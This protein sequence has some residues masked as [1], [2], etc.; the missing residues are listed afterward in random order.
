MAINPG[1]ACAR[2]DSFAKWRKIHVQMEEAMKYAHKKPAASAVAEPK[3]ASPYL[4]MGQMVGRKLETEADVLLAVRKG[5]SA[6]AAVGFA[7][8]RAVDPKLIAPESTLRRRVEN[9]QLL[10][11]D[12]SERMMRLARISSRAEGLF[13]DQ[14]KARVWLL[15]PKALVSGEP[16]ISPLEL[17]ITESGARIVEST[18]LR[19]EHGMP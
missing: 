16:P 9:N 6:R 19:A 15:T 2:L 14:A 12:E 7:E 8:G 1:V 5:L 10:T 4:R 3:L 11:V 17:A 18:L 13:G